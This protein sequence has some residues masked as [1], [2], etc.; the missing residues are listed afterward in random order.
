MARSPRH[1]SQFER[2]VLP[3]VLGLLVLQACVTTVPADDDDDDDTSTSTSTASAG[4]AGGM[5]G[6][7][8]STSTSSSTSVTSSS[9][10]AGGGPVQGAGYLGNTCE[11]DANCGPLDCLSSDGPGLGPQGG[12][13]TKPCQNSDD[14]PYNGICATIVP[15]VNR[16]LLNCSPGSGT[17]KSGKCRGRDDLGCTEFQSNNFACAPA[18]QSDAACGAGRS[19]NYGTGLCQDGEPIGDPMG[20]P[21]NPNGPDTCAGLCLCTNAGCT[22]GFCSGYCSRGTTDYSCGALEG[23]GACLLILASQDGAGDMGA[24][25]ALCQC[26]DDCTATD[27]VCN[28]LSGPDQQN[29]GYNGACFT[30]FTTSTFPT[31]CSCEGKLCGNDGC[32]GSCG[33][34]ANGEAC[35]A[36]GTCCTTCGTKQ[37]GPDGCGGTC[38]TCAPNE[39]CDAQG[40]CQCVPDCTGKTCGAD[41]CGGSC[42]SCQGAEVCNNGQCCA[43][44]CA[45]KQCGPDGCGGSC[46]T[47]VGQDVCDA[48]G[49]CVCQ[50]SCGGKQCGPNGCGGTCGSCPLGD[51]CDAAGQCCSP[52][53]AGKTCGPNGCGGTCGICS[54]IC[55]N[56]SC[57]QP[58]LPCTSDSQCCGQLCGLVTQACYSCLPNG[59]FCWNN[60]DCCSDACNGNVCTN[61]VNEM[62]MCE[63]N[64]QCCNGR[65][66]QYFGYCKF[67]CSLGGAGCS[68]NLQCCSGD[69]INGMC[70]TA[71]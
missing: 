26:D 3:L 61:C 51:E 33:N 7:N 19:C 46:G 12:M 29:L 55:N 14:C 65:C 32:S 2:L 40:Q 45:G 57:C 1:L 15:G 71:P 5:T 50:P 42:G 13:C 66:S 28:V 24:C 22:D 10:S 21:C 6:A 25:M 53:C 36:G 63:T 11:G 68:F 37:C 16:C 64:S 52:N 27:H 59:E 39:V 47:C 34:C 60:S 8:S 48:Q 62:G 23:D 17:P 70:T 49:Q 41:G 69:C 30:Q 31:C 38:G 9:S 56:G 43:P 54:G 58:T 18:C 67:D 44:N 4:G 35:T 20:T